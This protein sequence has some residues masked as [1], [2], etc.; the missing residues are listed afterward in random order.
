CVKMICK[1]AREPRF[2]DDFALQTAVANR[3][4]ALRVRSTLVAQ[5]GIEIASVSVSAAQG[6]VVLDGMTSTG[7]LPAR[8][9][10]WAGEV[11]G[12]REVEPRI[13]SMPSHGREPVYP[14]RPVRM[15]G[16]FAVGGVFDISARLMGRW[17]TEHMGQQF[18]IENRLG[19]RGY[20][21]T[22]A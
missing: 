16:A 2:Q 6:R 15:I 21:T 17:L 4:L 11:A 8:A 19:Q 5:I 10:K 1:L 7:G 14:R 3:L 22:E 13:A 9:E 20:P 18:V 12:V